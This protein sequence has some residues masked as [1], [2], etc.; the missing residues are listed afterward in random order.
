MNASAINLAD[1][2]FV[3]LLATVVSWA[4]LRHSLGAVLKIKQR[5]RKAR[6]EPGT[7]SMI[8]R[9]WGRLIRVLIQW[10]AR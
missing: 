2:H 10:R 6:A 3:Y 7:S 5:H 9:D 8:C 1:I 4:I